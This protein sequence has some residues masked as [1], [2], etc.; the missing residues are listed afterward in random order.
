[1]SKRR[2]TYTQVQRSMY[3]TQRTMGDGRALMRGTLPKRLI[4]RSVTRSLFRLFR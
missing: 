2:S 1:M 3:K 4:R